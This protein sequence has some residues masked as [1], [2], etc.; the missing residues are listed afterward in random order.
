MYSELSANPG[1]TPRVHRVLEASLISGPVWWVLLVVGPAGLCWLAY[2]RGR[3][4]WLRAVPVAVILG[5]TVAALVV[6]TVDVWWRPFPDPLPRVVPVWVG[7]AVTALVLAVLR[8]VPARRKALVVLVAIG[9]VISGAAQVNEHFGYAPS[10]RAALGLPLPNQVA[11]TQLPPAQPAPVAAAADSTLSARWS[12]PAGMP[13]AGTVTSAAVPGTVSGFAAR[14]AWIYLP[15]AYASTPRALLPVLVLLPGQPGE[16]R[17]WFNAGHLAATMDTYAAAHGGLAP[18]VVVADPLGATLA[19]PLCVDS[20]L[21][22]TFTYLS[23]DVPVWIRT[24]LQVDPNPR[25]WAVG[26]LSFGGTCSLQLA[27]NAPTVYPTFLDFSGQAEPTLGER[28]R[29]VNAAFGGD[30]AAFARVNPLDVLRHQRFPGT[31]GVITVGRDDAEYGPQATRVVAATTAAGMQIHYL[32]LPGGHA[33]PVW[34]SALEGSLS[35][36]SQRTGLTP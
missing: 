26:G 28:T 32:A 22:H 35:F 29:T 2:G 25:H 16:P 12:P 19:N 8:P 9:V 21:G 36:L 3:R 10:P 6:L 14:D 31:A 17:D 1:H 27:V 34:A 5:L 15:P 4:W 7:L 20:P 24:H 33:W 18:V 13:S 11:F 30:P 23:V